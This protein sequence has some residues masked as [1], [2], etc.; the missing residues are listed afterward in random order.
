MMKLEI[1]AD[2]ELH[3]SGY[4]NVA[5]RRSRPVITPRGRVTEEIESGAFAR[6]LARADNIALT[7]DHEGLV[8]AE[9]RAGTLKLREDNIGLHYD[10]RIRHEPTIA[11]AR[12][13]RIKGLSFGMRV[14]EDKVEERTGELPLRRVTGLDL[15]HITLVINKTPVYS[16]TSVE[17]RAGNEADIEIRSSGDEPPEGITGGEERN[18]DNSTFKARADKLKK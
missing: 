4:A 7:R 10:A 15:D 8:L 14:T 11:D 5:E 12:A 1:R 17:I 18:Y 13:G 9:T 3:I 6:A 2:G 16:A